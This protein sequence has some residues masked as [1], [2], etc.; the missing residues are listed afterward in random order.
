MTGDCECGGGVRGFLDSFDGVMAGGCVVM[1]G[2]R[3]GATNGRCEG[4]GNGC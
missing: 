2:D 4:D 1:G 3:K